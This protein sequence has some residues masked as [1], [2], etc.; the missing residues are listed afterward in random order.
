M[1]NVADVSGNTPK[2]S[3]VLAREYLVTDGTLQPLGFQ[4]ITSLS[5]ATVLTVPTGARLAL[6]QCETQNVRW[7]DDGT[8]PTATVGALLRT[9][10]DFWY[11]GKL[12]AMKFIETTA[13]ASLNV[14]YYA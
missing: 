8:D 3:P 14:S 13:S 9:G 12:S 7:R 5:A 10:T 6:L 1:S 11:S 2:D 4:R